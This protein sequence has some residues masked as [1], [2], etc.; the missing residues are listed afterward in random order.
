MLQPQL[1]ISQ[2]RTRRQHALPCA[3]GMISNRSPSSTTASSTWRISY[4]CSEEGGTIESSSGA[5][6]RGG[7]GWQGEGCRW[8]CVP[9]QSAQPAALHCTVRWDWGLGTVMVCCDKQAQAPAEPDPHRPPSQRNTCAQ[10]ASPPTHPHPHRR[11]QPAHLEA[12]SALGTVGGAC[13]LFK[14]R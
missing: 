7:R 10:A 12:G 5:S 11:A 2:R 6:L 1:Q 8:G 14:G 9:A 3:P 4:G 13:W